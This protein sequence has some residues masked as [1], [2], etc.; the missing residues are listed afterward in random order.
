MLSNTNELIQILL[1]KVASGRL[2]KRRFMTL[3]SA[4]GLAAGISKVMVHQ[5]LAAG[6]TRKEP[7][8]TSL[9]VAAP[10]A[11]S[12]LANYQRPARQ[13]WSWNPVV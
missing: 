7:T 9:S 2:S 4:A 12:S 8:T 10:R 6:E 1:D 5:A 11:P 3:A 13:S